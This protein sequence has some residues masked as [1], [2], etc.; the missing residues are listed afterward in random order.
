MEREVVPVST[1]KLGPW[2]LDLVSVDGN[3]THTLAVTEYPFLDGA[4]IDDM[5]T[6]P[7]KHSFEC[8]I[9]GVKFDN[10]YEAIH[11]WF[12]KRFSKPVELFHPDFGTL[13]GYPGTAS[14]KRNNRKHFASFSFEFT[15]SGL[16]PEAQAYLDVKRAADDAAIS[17]TARSKRK[18][19]KRCRSS[20]SPMWKGRI[21]RCWTNGGRWVPPPVALP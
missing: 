12:L 4:D 16:R 18:L 3:I 13:H 5:G 6:G 14:F 11:D 15:V 2:E 8:V 7:E 21:G 20:A 17:V 10:E 9:N 19:R 1:S